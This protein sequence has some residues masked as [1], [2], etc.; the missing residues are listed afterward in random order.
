VDSSR[1]LRGANPRYSG[2]TARKHKPDYWLLVI[3]ALLLTIGLVVVYSISPGLSASQHVSQSHFVIKQLIDVILG[4]GAFVIASY[5]PLEVWKKL[6]KPL[7][8]A[9]L[10]GCA[11]VMIT[12]IDQEFQ[13]HRWIRM[14]G[15]SFQVAELIKL[16]ILVGLADFLALRWKQGRLADVN[17]TIKPLIGLLLFIGRRND[18]HDVFDG[19]RSW[20]TT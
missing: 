5:I 2:E 4:V 3:S 20:H 8:I 16:A 1:R 12:P 6:A 15:F 17:A 11:L 18:R 7:V 14:G 10:V 19:L 9:S 13:A